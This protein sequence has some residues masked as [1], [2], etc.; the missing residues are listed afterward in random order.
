MASCSLCP[1]AGWEPLYGYCPLHYTE[2]VVQPLNIAAYDAQRAWA[3]SLTPLYQVEVAM[4]QRPAPYAQTELTRG[5]RHV[6]LPSSRGRAVAQAHGVVIDEP[7]E[8]ELG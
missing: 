4:G 3:D 1:D 2:Q 8:S 5:P 7:D 6:T